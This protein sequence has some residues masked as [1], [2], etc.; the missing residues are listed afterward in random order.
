[1][2]RLG[3]AKCE[4]DKIAFAWK[5]LQSVLAV[6]T[7]TRFL[8]CLLL[9]FFV[10]VSYT[11]LHVLVMLGRQLNSSSMIMPRCQVHELALCDCL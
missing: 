2:Y 3:E 8:V 5:C 11:V 7:V 1:M 6:T 4:H 9:G 10:V